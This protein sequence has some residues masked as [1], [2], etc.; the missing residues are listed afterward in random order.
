MPLDISNILIGHLVSIVGGGVL[1]PL[2]LW[3]IRLYQGIDEKPKRADGEPKRVP[4]ALTGFIERLFFTWIVAF[5]I[6]GAA[7]A[8]I[9][10]Q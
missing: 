2:V 10:W 6:S 3:G 9:G 5:D 4:G 8:M 1:V 7:T